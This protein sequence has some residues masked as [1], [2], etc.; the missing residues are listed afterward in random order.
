MSNINNFKVGCSYLVAR[1]SF[2]RLNASSQIGRNENASTIVI[3]YIDRDYII[4]RNVDYKELTYFILNIEL[5][6][7]IE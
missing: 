2:A 4:E 5:P 1:H 6:E 7:L 3:C